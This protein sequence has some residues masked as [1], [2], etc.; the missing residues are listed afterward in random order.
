MKSPTAS[1]KT[2]SFVFS[3]ISEYIQAKQNGKRKKCIY[4]VPTRLLI[5]SQFDNLVSYLS[6]FKV[7]S[8]IL[9]GGLL[10]RGR[11]GICLFLFRL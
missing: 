10:G 8:A 7:P 2:L 4:L 11:L 1:G 3:F 5:Q 6:Q 9:E